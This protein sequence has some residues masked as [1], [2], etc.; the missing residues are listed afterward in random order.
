MKK[1]RRKSRQ[2]QF[3]KR[4]LAICN[5]HSCYNFAFVLHNALVFWQSEARNFFLH[6]INGKMSSS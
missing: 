1:H 2:T 4:A 6:I 3:G 5:F